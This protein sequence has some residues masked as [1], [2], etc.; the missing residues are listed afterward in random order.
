MLIP[1]LALIIVGVLMA[2]SAFVPWPFDFAVAVRNGWHVTVFPPPLSVSAL[3][4]LSGIIALVA[5]FLR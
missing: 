1:A 2:A 5:F 4:V 3:V